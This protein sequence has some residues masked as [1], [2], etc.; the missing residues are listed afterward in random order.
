MAN[1]Q[2]ADYPSVVHV[3]EGVITD[4]G[5][6]LGSTSLTHTEHHDKLE[7]EIIEIQ[8][9]VGIGS[10]L[11]TG[12][13]NGQVLTANG[14]GTTSWQ[15]P[16][17]GGGGGGTWGSINGTLSNQTDLQAALDGKQNVI[18]DSDDITQGVS[19][20]FLTSAERTKL[21]NT[22]GTN[23][24]DQDL[25]GYVPITRTVNGHALSADVTISK[26]DVGL[27]NVDN[28]SDATKN[29]AIATLTNKTTTGLK[30]DGFLDINGNKVIEID[31][32]TAST[33]ANFF[34]MKA[35]ATGQAVVFQV[36]GS[37]TDVYANFVT[38]GSG[39]LRANGVD[40]V[41]ISDSQTLTNK[42][43]T[44]PVLN[45]ATIGTSLLPTTDDGAALGSTS[46]EFSDLFLASGGV[47][48][49]ANGNV[50]L[51][52]ATGRIDLSSGTAVRISS[53]GSLQFS[54]DT[55]LTRGGA[56]VLA[57]GGITIPTISSTNAL[58]NKDLTSGTNT[59]PTFNQNTTGS[60]ATLTTTRTIWGQNFNGSANVTGDLTLGTANLTMTG[61]IASTL[62]RVTKGWFTDLEIT[63]MPTV[64]GT[65]LSSTFQPLDSDLTTIAGL[66]ATTDNFIVSVASAWA[67]R[68]PS[69][70]RT[71]LGLVIGTNVQAYDADLDTWA[72][73]TPATGVGTFLATP[74]SANLRSA[75]TDET[76]TGALVFATSPGFTTA[77]NPVSNDGAALGTTALQWSDLFLAS[78]AVLNF[79]NGDVI[80][81]HS[82]GILTVGTGELRV[83]NA[84]TN[85]ASVVTVGGTQT[86]TNKTLTT[87][88]IGSFTN[89]TH[90]HSNA[91]G[92]GTF[93][94]ANLT[95][96]TADDHSQ[97]IEGSSGRSGN[98]TYTLSSTATPTITFRG[99]SSAAASI[100]W[101]DLWAV[102]TFAETFPNSIS[103]MSTVNG[104]G[105]TGYSTL[106]T[107]VLTHSTSHE[108]VTNTASTTNAT[109]TTA[110]SYT[111]GTGKY[112]FVEMIFIARGTNT[113]NGAI[114]RRQAAFRNNSGTVSQIGTTI[115]I[116]S[117][118]EDDS[119]WDATID[120]SGTAIRG[121]V[122]GKASTN[123]TWD[124]YA[125]VIANY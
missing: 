67:S 50:T 6:A 1:P 97:Y 45:T 106:W 80:A 122:T 119:T 35:A 116:G 87:P 18:T 36:D 105:G 24:G 33:G 66:T 15:D 7:K 73:I 89:A 99:G 37:D 93:A 74:S 26:S 65:S 71:T 90:D 61:S 34:I 72:T 117:D 55:S 38:K 91:A 78:G 11:A 103:A 3:L 79:A 8:K 108:P 21:S 42:T 22:S 85:S 31:E 57:V 81:T 10:A 98:Q 110:L 75:V 54:S 49:F 101:R 44:S 59:F 52:H 56:G 76:G 60:A 2:T 13:T 102:G 118:L 5:S 114:Y 95:S 48:N 4:A 92:G 120:F 96:R 46:K 9:K 51:T 84:G 16:T 17:G 109:Q 68:T 19:H 63:N 41:T 12:A 20:L 111:T 115:T 47:I 27:A 40:V 69:Q 62:S 77:A 94:H 83:T 88:T 100:V 123:I 14:D 58:T 86:L 70:V 29:S 25:S 125:I 82:T 43:L 23:T 32:I 107:N 121:R 124:C 113:N 53:T 112:Y 28:T 30:A 39:T 104:Y 64:N